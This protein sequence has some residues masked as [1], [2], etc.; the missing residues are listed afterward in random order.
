[1]KSNVSRIHLCGCWVSKRL[2]PVTRYIS[3]SG[4]PTY[5][6]LRVPLL[7]SHS[8]RVHYKWRK[9]HLMNVCIRPQMS[10]FPL[11]TCT[12]PSVLSKIL[13]RI[14]PTTKSEATQLHYSIS[15]TT[16]I[17]DSKNLSICK[18][19]HFLQNTTAGYA[20]YRYDKKHKLCPTEWH[21]HN[22]NSFKQYRSTVQQF[23]YWGIG[24]SEAVMTYMIMYWL[25]TIQGT[26]TISLL[27]PTNAHIIPIQGHR[28]R[29]TGFETAIT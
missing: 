15:N 20:Q 1:M 17:A 29:W 11:I 5:H 12:I 16:L 10:T 4:H 28:K 18:W 7:R 8:N 27:L 24:A 6:K 19:M 26:S 9:H 3:C 13:P 14:L 22:Q 21:T 2:F 23:K 25:S